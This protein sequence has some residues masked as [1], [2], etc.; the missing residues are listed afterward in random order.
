[1]QLPQDVRWKFCQRAS[2]RD[3]LH[4]ICQFGIGDNALNISFKVDYT[5]VVLPE[6]TIHDFPETVNIRLFEGNFWNLQPH[7]LGFS[8]DVV[9]FYGRKTR[10]NVPFGAIYRFWDDQCTADI[11][12]T[13]LDKSSSEELLP[14]NVLDFYST[15]F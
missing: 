4:D 7:Y 9:C 15:S 12:L 1:M 8:V 10:I 2:I 13:P 11:Q 5:G 14:K 3:I 6:N